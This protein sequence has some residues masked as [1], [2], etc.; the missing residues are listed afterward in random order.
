VQRVLEIGKTGRVSRLNEIRLVM[1]TDNEPTIYFP[2]GF[3]E[4]VAEDCESKGVLYHAVVCLPG[5]NRVQVGFY[6]PIRLSGDL[7]HGRSCV[8][9]PGMIVVPSVTLECMEKA[10]KELFLD[11]YFDS[12][13]PL[14]N[15]Q[16]FRLV[17]H[18]D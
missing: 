10:V 16:D 6:E 13:A 3:D 12:L 8:A 9:L 1:N 7:K 14:P 17:K 18:R 11:G 2:H 15:G 5:G 4:Y